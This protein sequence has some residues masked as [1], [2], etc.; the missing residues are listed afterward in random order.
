MSAFAFDALSPIDPWGYSFDLS[1]LLLLLSSPT[2][3]PLG[4][5]KA[6]GG[7][8]ETT[9]REERKVGSADE[10]SV[11][12][13]SLKSVNNSHVEDNEAISGCAPRPRS[14]FGRELGHLNI[15]RIFTYILSSLFVSRGAT[16]I[17]DSIG[18]PSIPPRVKVY[19]SLNRRASWFKDF[20]L[21]RSCFVVGCYLE[22]E[23][24]ILGRILV[25]ESIIWHAS[26]QI[27]ICC[28]LDEELIY[29]PINRSNCIELFSDYSFED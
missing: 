20:T 27:F 14:S 22:R 17:A 23:E 1:L 21:F 4:G 16:W 28:S 24:R 9:R 10:R 26:F 15:P 18:L 29:G 5:G 13:R 3:L 25:Y 8:K 7:G 19:P 12:F 11:R 2:F 6:L